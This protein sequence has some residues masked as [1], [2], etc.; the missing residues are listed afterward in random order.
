MLRI[1]GETA[2]SYSFPR[3]YQLLV[4]SRVA[5]AASRV[6]MVAS[7]AATVVSR[8]ATAVAVAATV[9][10]FSFCIQFTFHLCVQLWREGTCRFALHPVHF[11]HVGVCSFGVR[12]VWFT[13][14]IFSSVLV[15][16]LRSKSPLICLSFVR[17]RLDV[18][19]WK[20]NCC[21]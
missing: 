15:R 20:I 12:R 10:V 19:G 16:L 17:G 11:S 6:A 1:K 7:R 9:C 13:C 5:M 4:V 21:Q 2:R 3:H 8:A 18:T 14:I